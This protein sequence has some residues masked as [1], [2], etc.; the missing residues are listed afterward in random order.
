LHTYLQAKEEAAVL[1]LNLAS[2]ETTIEIV[3]EERS[4]LAKNLQDADEGILSIENQLR[5]KNEEFGAKIDNVSTKALF[6]ETQME[7]LQSQLKNTIDE[8]DSLKN[9]LAEYLDQS[10]RKA[11]NN[12]GYPGRRNESCT[13]TRKP[14]RDAVC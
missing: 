4:Q 13:T 12:L 6:L 9:Q 2:T 14:H 1:R 3:K 5:L 7:T 11:R 8:R 10:A